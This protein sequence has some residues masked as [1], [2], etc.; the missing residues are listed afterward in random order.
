MAEDAS[1]SDSG[2]LIQFPRSA[3][4]CR[5]LCNLG[6][7]EA[8]AFSPLATD[9]KLP[10]VEGRF[11]PFDHQLMT[12]AFIALHP[13]CYVLSEPRLGKTASSVL[14]MDWLQRH[15][16]V[17]GGV[18]VI[19]TFTTLKSVWHDGIRATLPKAS[20]RI[21]HGP[22]RGEALEEPAEFYVTN[23]DSVRLSEASFV[24]AVKAGRIGAVVV[25]ELTHVGNVT[26]LRSKAISRICA[27]VPRVVGL[28]GSPADNPT[29][30]FGMATAVNPC[31]RPCTTLGGWERLMYYQWGSQAWQRSVRPEADTTINRTLQ[32][33][34]RYRKADVLDL[35][36]VT[37]QIRSCPMTLAQRNAMVDLKRDAVTLL[38]SGEQITAV[39][40]GVLLQ[41]CLQI[42][43]GVVAGV[44]IDHAPRTEVLLDVI[45]ETD[46][47]V[48]V[49]SPFVKG[50]EMLAREVSE[51]GF[52]S[53]VITGAT[54]G[55]RRAE[56]LSAFQNEKD[57][58]VLVCHPMTVG[59]GTELSAADTMVFSV[60]LLLG[61]FVYSQ[62][63]E[64]LSSVRQTASNIN[65]IHLVGSKVEREALDKLRAGYK[66]A[67][68]IA[69]FF[70][71]S[72]R[73]LLT[74]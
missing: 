63:L 27:M 68:V 7:T 34:I 61:G 66:Y 55:K 53:L 48:V 62:A 41:R 70:E 38:E 69:E 3:D 23:Y 35:P 32:P 49:Y 26:T 50:C 42:A 4:A 29:A 28:T 37:E 67:R 25:D 14:A 40:G 52:S 59:F 51:A 33:S 11:K 12:S 22:K 72:S 45:R 15:G 16:E 1:L 47:K 71:E 10:L 39:N 73:H 18:L 36:P 60:P 64:R 9:T 17:V 24:K 20:V 43:Q 31:R 19:T 74:M 46:R 30:V 57:P 8:L 54:S 6:L 21:V 58:R 5:I 44:E 13:R 2:V 56:I 65:I